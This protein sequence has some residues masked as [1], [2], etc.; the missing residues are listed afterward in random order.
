MGARRLVLGVTAAAGLIQALAWYANGR[1]VAVGDG[2]SWLYAFSS[3]WNPPLG[4][5]P[6]TAVVCVALAAYLVAARTGVPNLDPVGTA[7]AGDVV[8]P[9]AGSARPFGWT[10]PSWRRTGQAPA[11]APQSVESGNR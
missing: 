9:G 11:P 10:G 4:W 3:K 5:L 6:W 8:S 2:G 1:R 7:A